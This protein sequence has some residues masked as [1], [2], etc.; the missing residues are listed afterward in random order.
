MKQYLPKKYKP[1]FN[2]FLNRIHAIINC[3]GKLRSYHF[4]IKL[5]LICQLQIDR[6]NYSSSRERDFNYFAKWACWTLNK[7]NQTTENIYYVKKRI[8]TCKII[9]FMHMKMKLNLI[10]MMTHLMLTW[11]RDTTII[12][13]G[14]LSQFCSMIGVI[15]H[16]C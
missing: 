13:G 7:Q 6:I 16:I 3:T 11:F 8:G 5:L 4:C 1:Q 10:M 14:K 9:Y 15:D 12:M 2:R